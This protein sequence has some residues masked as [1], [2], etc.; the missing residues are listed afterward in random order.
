MSSVDVTRSFPTQSYPVADYF[1]RPGAAFYIPLYQ[2]EYSWDNDNVEQLV[3]DVFRGVSALI[4]T[5]SRSNTIR[6]L[7]TIITVTEAHPHQ[8]ID[9][10]DPT[11]L[12][13]RIEKVIDGQQRLSTIALLATALFDRLTVHAS[14]LQKDDQDGYYSGLN[15]TADNYKTN[16]LEVF[17]IDLRRGK[18]N[19]KPVVIRGSVDQW[20]L[21]G[22]EEEN[23]H[24]DIALHLAGCIRSYLN[25]KSGVELKL[26]FPKGK[27]DSLVGK[28]LKLIYEK[29][30]QVEQAHGDSE[31]SFPSIGDIVRGM[32]QSDL[33]LYD[34]PELFNHILSFSVTGLTN[35][36]KH[37][38]SLV[39]LF[40]FCHYLLR[41][42]CFTVIEPEDETWAFDMFQSLNATGTPLTSVETF[43]PLVVNF[44]DRYDNGFKGSESEKEFQ[45]IDNLMN[46]KQTA[47]AKSKMTDAFL[48]TFALSFDG[49][50]L[51]SQFSDQRNWLVRSYPDGQEKGGQRSNFLKQ[52][53]H[54][55]KY[56]SAVD[57]FGISTGFAIPELISTDEKTRK[58]APLCFKYLQDAGHKMAHTVLSRFYAGICIDDPK[59]IE[60][61]AEAIKAVAAFF[62]LWRSA[63]S[64][65]GLD[66]VYRRILKE[67]LCWIKLQKTPEAT[68]LKDLFKIALANESLGTLADWKGRAITNLSYDTAPNAV[69]R[70]ALFVTAH[71]TMADPANQGLMKEAATGYS[72]YLDPDRWVSKDLESIEHV[73]P[74][75]PSDG[76]SWSSD[77]YDDDVYDRIGNLTLLPIPINSSAGNKSWLEKW[78]Y[79]R[80]LA[81]GD[82]QEQMKL[83]GEASNDGLI[84]SPPTLEKLQAAKYAQHVVPLV[85]VAKGAWDKQLVEKRTDRICDLV[86]KRMGAWLA[87]S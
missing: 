43:K 73:A 29:L 21:T 51:S 67:N 23:Y 65:S 4:D 35:Q 36:Q 52:M 24:S 14:A 68:Q 58:E 76:S 63:K 25:H 70:F 75:K 11:A 40:A 28:N 62:T 69:I 41:R 64:N 38:C 50:K 31:G 6:F 10:K 84:L 22:K 27:K 42:C 61:F 17:S 3:D 44:A 37:V 82:I 9:P 56:W 83:A 49:E 48:T 80:H 77:L 26:N 85:E 66:N 81:Q 57:R 8:N 1:V 53:G 72:V 74:Q 45:S 13:T 71:D 87:M 32:N 55:A 59:S 5:K 60:N 18:P 46:S 47:A 30:K 79:Y 54:M 20:T 86:W 33:W 2:R 15:E 7:G 34:R 19:L 12:P 39:Q 16:L 78:Y